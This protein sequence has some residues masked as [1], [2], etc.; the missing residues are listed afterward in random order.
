[1]NRKDLRKR[2]R[3]TL[4]HH[5]F[6]ILI[7]VFI[8]GIIS[9]GGYNFGANSPSAEISERGISALNL[10][11]SDIA[12][13]IIENVENQTVQQIHSYTRGVIAPIANNVIDNNSFVVGIFSTIMMFI[14]SNITNA[15]IATATLI[16][17]ILLYLFFATIITVGKDRY[18]LEHR[19]YYDAEIDRLLFVFKIKQFG[20]VVKVE[21]LKYLKLML[22]LATIF[23]LPVKYYEYLQIDYIL[24][25]N[26]SIKAKDA[27]TISKEMMKGM[28]W[29]AFLLDA[30]FLGW[31]LLNL[32]SF[33]LLDIFFVKMYHEAARAELYMYLRST[34]PLGDGLHLLLCDYALHPTTATD[35]AYP[36]DEYFIS[37]DHSSVFNT[38]YSDH[39]TLISY[40]LMFFTFSFIGW[41]WEVVLHLAQYGTFVNRGSMVGPWLPIYGVGGIMSLVLLKGFKNN[42]K[43]YFVG[44]MLLCGVVEYAGAYML[45]TITGLKYWD[46]TGMFLNIDGRICFEGLLVFGIGCMAVC[47]FVAPFLNTA[48]TLINHKILVHLCITFISLFLIDLIY[49]A[50]HPNSGE[51]ITDYTATILE[52]HNDI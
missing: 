44:S 39:Y 26:P 52:Y 36:D 51:G 5:Y 8:F 27:F 16:L 7:V 30:S 49:S 34:K 29:Q 28:K 21:A 6:K 22:W 13:E 14:S 19:R 25:E 10:P 43:Y 12:L 50:N 47:Y 37:I 42:P 38:E 40:I 20:N 15:T 17:M 18:F 45:E 1:M 3:M 33:G 41:I 46:Y 35:S 9:G 24:A 48:Y 11:N 2:A 32:L 4:K 31:H 23:M